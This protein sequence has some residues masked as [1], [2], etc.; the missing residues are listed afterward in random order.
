ME[1]YSEKILWYRVL[2]VYKKEDKDLALESFDI[3]NGA[4]KVVF[5]EL[6]YF[7]KDKDFQ[8]ENGY[9]NSL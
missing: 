3:Y 9:Y 2:I 4:V 7:L 1:N 5:N 6:F 8:L